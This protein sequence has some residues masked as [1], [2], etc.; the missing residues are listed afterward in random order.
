MPGAYNSAKADAWRLL[1]KDY[2]NARIDELLEDGGL[3]DQYV[4]K[5]LLFL[6]TQKADF[7]AKRGA[8]TEY[9]KLKKRIS[10]KLALTGNFTVTFDKQDEQL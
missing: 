7:H 10:D 5:Q 8:I 6:I 1:T 2:I 9:N 4:D 3:N